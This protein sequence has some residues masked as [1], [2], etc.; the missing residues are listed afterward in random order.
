[1]K[2]YEGKV[3]VVT[4]SAAGIGRAIVERL[5][6]EGAHVLATSR[7]GADELAAKL[8][9]RCVSM[10]VDIGQE[11][12]II[13]MVEAAKARFGRIDVA[14][15]V[16]NGARLGTIL[17]SSA[18][19]WRVAFDVSVIGTF[20][21]VRHEARQMIEAGIR[22]AIVNVAS[23]NADV[24]ARGLSSY[25]A[26]KAAIVML[27]KACSIEFAQYGVRVNTLSPGLTGTAVNKDIPEAMLAAFMERIPVGR[28]ASPEEQAEAAL[29]LGSEQASYICGENLVVDGGWANSGYPDTRLWFGGL[30]DDKL[31]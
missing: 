18:A 28:M 17:G 14:F 19:E 24:P 11:D 20:N 30:L 1:M 15:N 4:A 6:A 29:F 13:A 22:G 12:Q 27:G 23:L 31:G 25:S 7:N 21:C 8:G 10:R 9:E 5:V 16:A 3:A 26:A 2:R